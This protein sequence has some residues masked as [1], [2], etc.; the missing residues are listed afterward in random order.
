MAVDPKTWERQ[1]RS[2]EDTAASY[3]RYRPSY[4]D[5]IFTD[6]RAYADLA[7]EDDRIL[8]IAC[9]TGK[10]TV[11]IASWPHAIVALEPAGAMADVAR[12]NLEG[13]DNV[14]V[15]TTTFEDWPIERN[16]FGLVLCAQA[17]HW[18]DP[19]TRIRRMSDALYAHGSA[20]I[21]GN[22]QVAPDDNLP[23]FERVQ[24]VYRHHAPDLMHEGAFRR[25]DDLP[26]HPF[27]GSDLFVDLE[28][29]GHPWSWTLS[30][31]DYVALMCT[32]SAHAA[33]SADDRI[34]LTEGI[35]ELI[36]SEFGG[37]VTEHH[38]ALVG[39]ARRT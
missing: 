13:H 4:P 3:D 31:T 37:Y 17:F 29:V 24:D 32:H 10:A 35:A 34:R 33:L 23:F 22:I 28:Q 16:A 18:L 12:A 11:K 9:G 14:E 39:L 15:I 19:A 27:E 6:I 21:L 7:P 36:D 25:P 5:A 38:V 2:F 20:A 26:P 30:A 1:R 8:E